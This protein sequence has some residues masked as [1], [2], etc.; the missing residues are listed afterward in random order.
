MGYK[1]KCI[2]SSR[3]THNL[4]PDFEYYQ[5]DYDK[6][7]GSLVRFLGGGDDLPPLYVMPD[8]MDAADCVTQFI[9]VKLKSNNGIGIGKKSQKK[10]KVLQF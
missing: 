9:I 6:I 2:Q 7:L 1:Y 4:T 5:T 10:L 3:V 8:H